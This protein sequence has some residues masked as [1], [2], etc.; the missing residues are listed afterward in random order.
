MDCP[1]AEDYLARLDERQNKEISTLANLTGWKTA[2]IRKAVAK[3][4]VK[5]DPDAGGRKWWDRLW[6]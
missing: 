4:G 2:E 3:S 6:D 5:L 1:A